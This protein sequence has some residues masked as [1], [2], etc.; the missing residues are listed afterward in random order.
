MDYPEAYKYFE[1][2]NC[3]G[4]TDVH[5]FLEGIINALDIFKYNENKIKKLSYCLLMHVNI[6]ERPKDP[7][8]YLEFKSVEFQIYSLDISKAFVPLEKLPGGCRFIIS[9]GSLG[10]LENWRTSFPDNYRP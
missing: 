8:D 4:F 5:D 7:S 9:S 10:P 6:G 1:I 3:N 2:S